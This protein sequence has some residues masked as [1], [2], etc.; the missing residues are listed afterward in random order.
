MGVG[1]LKVRHVPHGGWM[2][3]TEIMAVTAASE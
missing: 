2:F 1:V 3:E